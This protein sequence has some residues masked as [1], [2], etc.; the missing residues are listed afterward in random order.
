[1]SRRLYFDTEN[2]KFV[3]RD[4]Q[5]HEVVHRGNLHQLEDILDHQ[6]NSLRKHRRYRRCCLF[7]RRRRR[8]NDKGNPT[9]SR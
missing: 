9:R 8:T 6:E 1:M 7:G 4:G 3:L 2:E 5:T